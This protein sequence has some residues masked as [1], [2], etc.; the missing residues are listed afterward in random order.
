MAALGSLAGL[1]GAVAYAEA[2]MVGLRTWWRPA[3]GTS[4]L[5]LHVSA[6]SLGVGYLLSVLVVLFAI[7]RTSDGPWPLELSSPSVSTISQWSRPE[8]FSK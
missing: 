3:V 4:E 7:W 6:L 5:Y 2:M 8:I 1:A